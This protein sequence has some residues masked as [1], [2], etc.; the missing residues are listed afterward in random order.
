VGN[1]ALRAGAALTGA[2]T[3]GDGEFDTLLGDVNFLNPDGPDPSIRLGGIARWDLVD[4]TYD[5][6]GINDGIIF[7]GMGASPVP[8]PAS[9]T[10]LAVGSIGLLRRRSA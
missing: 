1:E 8:E 4:G 2:D 3:D 10:L 6:I 5:I 9:L 7:F